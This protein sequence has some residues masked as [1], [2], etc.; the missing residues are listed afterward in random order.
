MAGPRTVARGPRLQDRDR[1]E[2]ERARHAGCGRSSGACWPLGPRGRRAQCRARA[3]LRPAPRRAGLCV[4]RRAYRRDCAATAV[5]A[6]A[7]SRRR[8]SPPRDRG[9]AARSGTAFT[10]VETYAAKAV[11]ALPAEAASALRLGTIDAVL[12]YSPRSAETYVSL[13]RRAGLIAPAL[14][15]AQL[16]LSAAVAEPLEAA[17]RAPVA[18]RRVAAR[19]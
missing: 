13:A 11:P 2:R 19:A 7:L 17:R 6:G 16:C 14:A 1:R 8:G 9:G 10:L 3:R 4:R 5:I 15:P 18:R 12:H